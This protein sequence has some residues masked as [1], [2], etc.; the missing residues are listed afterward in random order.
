MCALQAP[1]VPQRPE[2]DLHVG[3]SGTAAGSIS[4][5]L[6]EITPKW[7]DS[8]SL[9]GKI[10]MPVSMCRILTTFRERGYGEAMA[11]DDCLGGRPSVMAASRGFL[12]T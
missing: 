2:M 6:D 9:S 1:I 12:V 8:D 5:N 4:L 7:C 10:Y 11:Q 3:C